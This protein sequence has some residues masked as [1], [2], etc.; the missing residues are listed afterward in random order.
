MATPSSIPPATPQP[1]FD[2]IAAGVSAGII[3]QDQAM[4]LRRLPVDSGPQRFSSVEPG[5]EPFALFRGFRDVFLALGI[6][7][8]ALGLGGIA[9]EAFGLQFDGVLD[10]GDVGLAAA[11]A[12][13]AWAVGEWVTGRLRMPLASLVTA[14]AFSLALSATLVLFLAVV[15]MI[16]VRDTSTQYIAF[17]LFGASAAVFYARFRLPFA[18]LLIAGSIAF[19]VY[20]MIEDAFGIDAIASF[21]PYAG[22][23]GLIIFLAALFYELKDPERATRFSENAFWLH[24]VAAPLIVFALTGG[25]DAVDIASGGDAVR[26]F[27]VVVALGLIALMIDRRAFI[28]SALLYLGGAIGYAIS[29]SGMPSNIQFASTAL[30]LGLFVVGLALGW[31]PLRHAFLRLLPEALS[32][33]LPNPAG[34][35]AL[36]G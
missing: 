12:T 1:A 13:I 2:R 6:I 8:L 18:M 33:R 16:A 11:L 32:E 25:L 20:R 27:L 22:L 9:T 5:D 36:G 4:A 15:E 19:L 10:W 3:T 17:G 34:P 24:L 23:I 30:V 7:I 35:D 14:S 29:Q 26:V 31:Q 21:Q 28:V